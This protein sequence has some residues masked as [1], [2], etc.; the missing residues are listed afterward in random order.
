MTYSPLVFAAAQPPCHYAVI[1]DFEDKNQ[2]NCFKTDANANASLSINPLTVKHLK[3][4]LK[5]NS[6]GPST[7]QLKHPKFTKIPHQWL[8]RGGVKVWFYKEAPTENKTMDIEFKQS[9]NLLG[10]FQVNLDFQ[11]WRGIWV[12]FSECKV[13]G[14]ALSKKSVEI[15][16]VTF[17]LNDAD[18]IYMDL[19]GFEESFGKQ[20]RDKVVPPIGGVDLYDAS[21]TWQRT[22]HWSQQRCPA[23]PLEIDDKKVKSLELITARMRNWFCDGNKTS[24]NF[25]KDSFH[26]KRWKSLMSTVKRAHKEYDK[27]NFDADGKVV[28]PPLFCR[29][30]RY[31]AKKDKSTRKFGF[32]FE[33]IMLPL[34]LE[35]YLRSRPNEIAEAAKKHLEELNSGDNYKENNAY[36]AIAGEDNGMKKLF[37]DYLP[38]PRPLK[39][40]DVEKAIKTLNL[41]R[42][43]KINNLLDFAKQQGFTDGSGFGSLDHEWNRDGAGFMNTLFLL[44]DSLSIPSNKTRLLD[45]IET[46]KW[47]NDFREIY[48]LPEFELKG[49]TA[50]RMITLLLYRLIIVLVMPSGNEDEL[51]AKIRDMDALVR[52]SNNAMAV[53][54][55]LGGV[56]K[57]DFVGF[58]HKAFYG[59]AYVPQA[60]HVAALV[61]YLLGGTEFALSASSTE[62]IRRGLETLRIIAVKSSTPNSVNGRFP[63]YYN[64]ALIK[65]VLP[66]YAYISVSHSSKVLSA[67]PT[68]ITVTN[69]SGAEMFL[70]L[71]DDPD[72]SSYL[73]DGGPKKAKCYLNS[74]GSLDIMEAVSNLLFLVDIFV[75]QQVCGNE[76][77]LNEQYRRYTRLLYNPN[78]NHLIQS[79]NVK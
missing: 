67:L 24:S 63:H 62:N 59:S 23:L 18:T 73:A 27:L 46:A 19:L 77:L 53:N 12:K 68:G 26:D 37:K 7:L 76:D 57:P 13:K 44:R 55:G 79:Q 1:F 16:E 33:K 78:E 42:L 72:V 36:N 41:D 6:S 40:E 9:H 22:Y 5:W 60:L 30:C 51:K 58:H 10:R 75:S 28:G 45:L 71:Y 38:K 35:Y 21:N 8:R 50:D 64:K 31:G 29:D 54:E 32:I 3:N 74:L 66:G 43:N 4:S 70:R 34:A 20:S 25:V 61:H 49:T 11:G 56:I 69:G 47:Y 15:D 17:F 14:K 48:Q 2:L 65:A 39:Q 52:W